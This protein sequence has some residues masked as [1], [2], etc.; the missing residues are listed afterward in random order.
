M[1]L[2]K[3]I[4]FDLRYIH[5]IYLKIKMKETGELIELRIVVDG[6]FQKFGKK[7]AG[8]IFFVAITLY[9]VARNLISSWK[10]NKIT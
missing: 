6:N 5:S 10:R 3:N 2:K 4:E 1:S 9:T 7:D 8:L